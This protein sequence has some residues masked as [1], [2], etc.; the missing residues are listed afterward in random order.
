MHLHVARPRTDMTNES[1]DQ[2]PKGEVAV[3]LV[4]PTSTPW[5][6]IESEIEADLVRLARPGV[7]LTYRCTGAGPTE[8]RTVHD[9]RAAAPFV[10]KTIVDAAREGFDAVIVDCTADPGVA[11]ARAASTFR[12][13]AQARRCGRR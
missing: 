3:L 6:A 10:V 11:E 4:G 8:I 13:S 12:S 9:A 7:K 2:V 1:D 5:D